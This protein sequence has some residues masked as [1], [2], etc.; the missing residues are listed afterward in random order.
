MLLARAGLDVLVVDRAPARA[1]ALSTHALMRGAV[2]QLKRWGL[3][4]AIV[5]ACTPPV[6]RTTFTYADAVVPIDVKPSYGVDALYAPRRT[7]LDPILARAAKDAGATIAYG[8]TVTGV[9]RQASGRVTGVEGRDHAGRR[10]THA[11]RWVIGADGIRSAVA[12]AVAAPVEHRGTGATAAVYGYWSELPVDG[13]E[14]VFRPN[15]CAGAIPTNGHQTCVF[16]SATPD[17]IGRG[18]IDAIRHLV[19][20][21]SPA[22]RE[23]LDAAVEP[24]GVRTFGG[25]PGYVRLRLSAAMNEEVDAIARLDHAWR[26]SLAPTG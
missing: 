20:E 8:T 24:A 2:V 3:L 15:A 26:G 1:D 22:L 17:R 14:W 4:D 6:L 9:T 21:A 16:A 13:Y 12:R 11:G 19:N 7:V 25:L 5:G 10:V 23:R 18:G